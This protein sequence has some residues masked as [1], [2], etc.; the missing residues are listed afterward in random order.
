M[1]RPNV[2]AE[3]REQ[4]LAATCAVIASKGITELRL[5]DVAEKAGV[6]S[7]TVHYYFETKRAVVN[8]AFE[9]NFRHSLDRR[10]ALL[11]RPLD[12]LSLLLEVIDSYAPDDDATTRAWRVWAELW[13]EGIREPELRQVNERLYADW[14]EVVVSLVRRAQRDGTVRDGDPV[15]F[16]NMLIAMIDGLALQVL[17]DSKDMPLETMRATLHAFVDGLRA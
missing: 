15:A 8:A 17:L 7:G 5:S 6:S 4:I 12:P 13:V 1:P 11:E 2:E 3:R 9:Y 16:A 10:R 14:R